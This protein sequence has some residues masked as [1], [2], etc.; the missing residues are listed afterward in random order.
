MS[1]TTKPSTTKPGADTAS[2]G[3]AGMRGDLRATRVHRLHHRFHVV[4]SERGATLA[5]LMGWLDE[6]RRLQHDL[7]L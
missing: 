7:G 1:G 4:N 2:V 6:A 3:N 5:Y